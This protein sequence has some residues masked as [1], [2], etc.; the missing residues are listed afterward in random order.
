VIPACTLPRALAAIR[1]AGIGSLLVE[2]GGRL[3][4]ALLRDGLVDRFYWIQSPLWLGEAG[5]PAVSGWELAGLDEAEHWHLVERRGL[6][7]DTLLV[8]DRE[9]CSPA[10]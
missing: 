7:P 6:G 8:L 4:G 2:G 1:R 3:A 10:S 9:A 5:V